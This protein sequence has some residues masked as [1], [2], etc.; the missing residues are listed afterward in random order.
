MAYVY[1]HIRLDKNEPFYIGIGKS[2]ERAYSKKN[3]NKYWKHIV[4]KSPYEIEILFDN[5][6]YTEAQEKEKEFIKLYGRKDLGNGT[7][8]NMTDGGEGTLNIKVSNE[9]R[10]KL[11]NIHK[12][13]K[14]SLGRKMKEEVRQL[15]SIANKNRI[16][17]DES[18]NKLSAY[19]K[20]KK[21]WD[22]KPHPFLGKKLTL[23]HKEK[24]KIVNAKI[25]AKGSDNL[26]AI[27]INQYTTDN[28]YIKT[29]GSSKDIE[30]ELEID[31][32]SVIK[33]CKGKLKTCKGYI[34]KYA[35]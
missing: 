25:Y 24:L 34:F 9:T 12:G 21:I 26:R 3:R 17:K 20:G 11:S 22:K 5:L 19:F 16:W 1:R 33:C 8:V 27:K 23:E 7:L 31:S 30:R 35:N 28:Q 13:N 14:Y 10:L 18:K 4:S 2:L 6:T 15:I 29:W 32:S